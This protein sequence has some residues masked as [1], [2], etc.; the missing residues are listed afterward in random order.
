[1]KEHIQVEALWVW[2]QSPVLINSV[3][4]GISSEENVKR[5][6]IGEQT[7]SRITLD[8]ERFHLILDRDVLTNQLTRANIGRLTKANKISSQFIQ[9]EFLKFKQVII[10]LPTNNSTIFEFASVQFL[11]EKI[12]AQLV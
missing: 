3:L 12:I 10:K 7:Y 4:E 5:K 6:R 11:H 9:D 8:Y 2:D 1:M